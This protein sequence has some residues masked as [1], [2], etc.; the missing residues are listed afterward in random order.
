MQYTPFIAFKKWVW[1]VMFV[2]VTCISSLPIRCEW[3][4]PGTTEICNT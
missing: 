4:E 3:M 1:K 2:Y